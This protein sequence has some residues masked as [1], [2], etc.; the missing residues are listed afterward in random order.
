[1]ALARE[2]WKEKK[3]KRG[4]A[5][6]CAPHGNMECWVHRVF[7]LNDDEAN[8]RLR[9]AWEQENIKDELKRRTAVLVGNRSGTSR[10]M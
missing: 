8:L 4:D 1:M 10:M 3:W 6:A 9:E 7:I 2:W 5:S